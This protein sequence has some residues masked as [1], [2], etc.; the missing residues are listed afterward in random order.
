MTDI[1]QHAKEKIGRMDLEMARSLG[2]D[3][4]QRCDEWFHRGK[5]GWLDCVECGPY[6]PTCAESIDWEWCAE[7]GLYYCQSCVS[8]AED[9]V[10]D[11]CAIEYRDH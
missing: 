6:C 11:V 1:W 7:C 9:F 2:F 8:G 3:H 4:C 5:E 10:C